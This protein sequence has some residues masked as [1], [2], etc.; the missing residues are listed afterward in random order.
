MTEVVQK[1]SNCNGDVICEIQILPTI[2][3]K[4]KLENNDSAPLEFGNILVFTC[5]KNCW[6][7]PDKMRIEN[8]VV[9]QEI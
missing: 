8:V 4:L 1:C 2:I 5:I 7:T 3:P 6:D 9:Q